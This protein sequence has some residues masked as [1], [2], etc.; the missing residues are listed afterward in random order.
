MLITKLFKFVFVTSLKYNIDES[1]G[2]THSMNVLN[3]AH[4]IYKNE[5]YKYPPI[6]DHDRIIYT[7]AIVHDMCDK[8]YM[9]ENEG[10]NEIE[11][12]LQNKLTY[13]ELDITKQIISTMSY[14]TVKK[15]GFPN[16]GK[17]QF[18]YHIVR[19][20]DLLSAYDFDRCMIYKLNHHNFDLYDAFDDAK[21]LFKNRVFKHNEHGLFVTDYAKFESQILHATAKKRIDDWE[22]IIAK[23]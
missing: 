13:E 10:I 2:L 4:N 15:N 5:L 17:Y 18:A 8:K 11:K 23:M 3:Y 1:H 22:N 20:A 19:E 7:S 12:F 9:N 21:Y 6:K 14:S 16:L